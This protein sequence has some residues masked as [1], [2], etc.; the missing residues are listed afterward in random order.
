[1]RTLAAAPRAASP[2]A[3]WPLAGIVVLTALA[4]WPWLRWA[5]EAPPAPRAEASAGATTLPA[6][7]PLDALR[8]TAE[9]PLFAPTRR[10]APAARA[11]TAT[12]GLRLEGVIAIGAERRAIIKRSDGTT[13][14]VAA[15]ET[16]G[17]WTVRRIEPDRVELAAGTRTLEL[18]AGR[19]APTSAPPR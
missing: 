5:L 12:L 4:L 13:A 11:A 16:V 7:P 8:E 3:A 19:A 1:M 18:I 15:G 10:P 2:R 14:R 6:L 17:E 9:R